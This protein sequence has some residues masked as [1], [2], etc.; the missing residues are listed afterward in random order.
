MMT[1]SY[2]LLLPAYL[3]TRASIFTAF[4]DELFDLRGV[5][6]LCTRFSG[7]FGK[8]RDDTGLC[9]KT[10]IMEAGQEMGFFPGG[11]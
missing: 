6:T 5:H 11:T 9:G 4:R 3:Y 8:D 7:R 1:P 2:P 10:D